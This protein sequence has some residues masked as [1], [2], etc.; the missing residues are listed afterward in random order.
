[1][2]PFT[3]CIKEFLPG[4]GFGEL[5]LLTDGIRTTTIITTEDTFF[6]TIS[7]HGFEEI[8]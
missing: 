5:A 6:M 7:R 2:Y 1:M 4:E 3:V 8:I